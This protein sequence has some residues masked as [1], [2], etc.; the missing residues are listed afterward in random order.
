MKEKIFVQ[1]TEKALFDF[2][3]YHT[4]SKFAGFLCNVLGMAVAFMGI[5]LVIMQKATIVQLVLYLIAAAAFIGFTPIQ[6][7]FRARKQIQVNSEYKEGCSYL[8]QEENLVKEQG[9]KETVF[10]WEQ[11]EKVVST[12]KTIGFYY[13]R[14]EALIIPKESFGER[15]VPTMQIVMKKVNPSKVNIR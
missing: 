13:G 4:Y 9:E 14:D 2:M 5:I 15:F 11:I 6:L 8:F 10:A 3:L 7:K 12:P 1:M